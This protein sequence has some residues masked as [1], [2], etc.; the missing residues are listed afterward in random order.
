VDLSRNYPFGW[1]GKGGD[2]AFT[3]TYYRGPSAGSE[4]ETQAI[5]ALAAEQRFTASISFHTI[6][7]VIYVPYDCDAT[8]DPRPHVAWAIAEELAAAAPAQRNGKGYRVAGSGYPVAGSDLD[9]HM[10]THGTVAL[11]LEGAYH[12]PELAIRTETVANTR[13][14]WQAL[15]EHVAR[16]PRISGHVLDEAGVP[17]QAEVT[18]DPIELRAGERW[19]SRPRDGR[20]DRMLAEGGKYTVRAEAPG[21]SPATREVR[22]TTRPV[23]VDLVLPPKS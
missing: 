17:V 9:W 13:P 4:P 8:L 2:A 19:T 16:G 21:R 23:E 3:G 1:G 6:G 5:M 18:I 22:V 12:N 20:F 7:R 11:L 15:L 14:V 10:F